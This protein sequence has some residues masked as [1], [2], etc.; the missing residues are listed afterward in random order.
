[1]LKRLEK[2]KWH[3]WHGNNAASLIK[4][5]E[6]EKETSTDKAKILLN[7]LYDYIE[8]NTKYLT[9]YQTKSSKGLP[10]TSTYAEESVNSI[11]NVRQKCNQKMQWGREG[12]QKIL[13]LRISIFSET[14]DED[15]DITKKNIYKITF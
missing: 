4:I 15:F 3:L 2:V 12:A 5:K 13:Q 7:Y 8:R 11:I 1:L 10:Y 14:W 6:L 9:N